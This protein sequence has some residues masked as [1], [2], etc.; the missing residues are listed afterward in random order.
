MSLFTPSNVGQRV[1][2]E[3]PPPFQP[4][5][6]EQMTRKFI[7]QMSEPRHMF[8]EQDKELVRQHAAYYNIPLYE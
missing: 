1:E 3:Q 5:W 6:D 7:K 2:Q 4:Q 8:N